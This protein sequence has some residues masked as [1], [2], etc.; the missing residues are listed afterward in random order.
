MGKK[1]ELGSRGIRKRKEKEEG[2]K[3]GQTTVMEKL[4]KSANYVT[5]QLLVL[6]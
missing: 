6:V 1:E 3:K 4:F 2:R 5:V